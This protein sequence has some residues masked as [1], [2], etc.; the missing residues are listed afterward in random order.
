[1]KNMKKK[2]I[3]LVVDVIPG[4][5]AREIRGYNQWWN[6]LNEL[7]GGPIYRPLKKGDQGYGIL[8]NEKRSRDLVEY[9]LGYWLNPCTVFMVEEMKLLRG[10]RFEIHLSP[11][12]HFRKDWSRDDIV[13][14][15]QRFS[16]CTVPIS[17][18]D[19]YGYKYGRDDLVILGEEDEGSLIDYDDEA[20]DDCVLCG[21][22]YASSSLNDFFF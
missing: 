14:L 11:N 17:Y 1:M 9:H 10:W 2:H 3:I 13:Q 8:H 16:S 20:E 18:K 15:I 19:G 6:I 12:K 5:M 7:T 21:D 4:L 22:S